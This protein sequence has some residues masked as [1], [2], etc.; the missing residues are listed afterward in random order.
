MLEAWLDPQSY[1]LHYEL[2]PELILHIL[3]KTYMQMSQMEENT[4]TLKI[5]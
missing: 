2:L 5:V 3:T 1:T 4:F